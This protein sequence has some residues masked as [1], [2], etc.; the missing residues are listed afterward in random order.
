MRLPHTHSSVN[1]VNTEG[2]KKVCGMSKKRRYSRVGMEGSWEE[3]QGGMETG[4]EG[5]VCCSVR[6]SVHSGVW[7]SRFGVGMEQKVARWM[8]THHVDGTYPKRY[9]NR[10]THHTH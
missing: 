7:R 5:N 4:L 6:V 3:L 8:R 2:I 10:I 9:K 1:S